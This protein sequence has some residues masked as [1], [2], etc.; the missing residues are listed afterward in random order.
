MWLL[1]TGI[2][3]GILELKNVLVSI[4]NSSAF[5]LGVVNIVILVA[6][7]ERTKTK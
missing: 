1:L 5:V 7:R 3:W 6:K 2:F 4:L